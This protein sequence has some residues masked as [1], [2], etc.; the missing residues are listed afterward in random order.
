LDYCV[1]ALIHSSIATLGQ[2]RIGFLA[3]S[4]VNGTGGSIG[5]STDQ[6]N[7]FH[8]IEQPGE[9]VSPGCFLVYCEVSANRLGA[10]RKVACVSV[11]D[12]DHKT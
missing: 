5:A 2:S 10:T 6:R 8:E 11:S 9:A 12:S 4:A 1:T 3:N 7:I